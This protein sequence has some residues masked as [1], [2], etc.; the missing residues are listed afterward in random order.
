MLLRRSSRV[1]A[2]LF[3][4]SLAACLAPVESSPDEAV[5]AEEEG[6]SAALRFDVA[7]LNCASSAAD[8]S[9]AKDVDK[10]FCAPELDALNYGKPHFLAVG[11]D[12]HKAEIRGAGN[13]QAVYVNALNVGWKGTTGAA[14]ADDLMK[15]LALDFPTGVPRWVFMN[16]IS[17]GTWPDH[18]DY[19]QF[20]VDVAARL[21]GAH[22]R[23]VI[24]AAPFARPGK[25]GPSWQALAQHAWIA[26][27][28]Y[29]TGAQINAT[30]NS[31]A[32]CEAQYRASANAYAALGVPRDRLML[33][34]HFGNT[35]AGEA[36]GRA[37]VSDAGWKNAIQ[38]RAKG[39]KNVGFAGYL[40]YLWGSNQ[41][42]DDEASR[43]D[44]I[45]TYAGLTLP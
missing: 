13:Y 3:A 17:A 36:W 24:I 20:V 5:D 26:A 15:G 34:E 39:A 29:L 7:T 9:C 8:E 31:A 11:T 33:V 1:L 4:L 42:H 37:G 21:S 43:L 2:S 16:E 32:W 12:Q 38:A 23:K 27:E 35:A 6:L 25:N 19:R 10:C 28:V 30:G 41:M 44:A 22:G 14:W 18:A 40:S 45:D